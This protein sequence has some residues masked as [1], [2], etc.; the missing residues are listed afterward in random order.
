MTAL[1]PRP[2]PR[3]PRPQPVLAPLSESAVFLTLTVAPG[4]EDAVA[5]L[6]AESGGLI[7]SVGFRVPDE[8]LSAVIGI[9]ADLW[10]RTFDRPRPRDLHPFRA[11]HGARHHAPA[12][13][14]DLFV[15]L[16]ARRMHP[17]FELAKLLVGRLGAAAR[18]VDE[19]HGF[20]YFDSRDL[21]GFVDGTENPVADEAAAAVVIGEQ[22]PDAAGGTYVMIQKYLHDLGA[23]NGISVE[24]QERAIGR[25]KLDDVELDDATKPANAHTA[26]TVVTDDDDEELAI[27]RD[28]MPFG[29][30]GSGEYGTYFVGYA[31]DPA[32]PERMLRNMVIGDPEGCTDRI[33]DF[34]TAV[35]GGLFFVPS[36]EFLDDPPPRPD[37]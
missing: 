33:L 20:R 15:H 10:D 2:S 31:A 12:T 9:G 37:R 1:A 35:T 19:V 17:C 28:N 3:A 13:P 4:G 18:V 36:Q 21:L 24:E 32:V 23:W 14:G 8:Q 16:R 34:S 30:V 7:R 29:S 11:L 6:L 27:L 22:D 25:R 5:D 26:L